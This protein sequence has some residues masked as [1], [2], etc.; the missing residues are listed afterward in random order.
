VR[1]DPR[2]APAVAA[3]AA[4]TKTAV[5]WLHLPQLFDPNDGV[6]AYGDDIYV[7]AL[8]GDLDLN[9]A[10]AELTE[11]V[12]ARYGFE[13][14][15]VVS[16]VNCNH[17]EGTIEVWHMWMDEPGAATLAQIANN[18]MAFCPT[19]SIE[20]SAVEREELYERYRNA[21][22]QEQGPDLLIIDNQF[23]ANL[24]IDG[25]V[26]DLTN[27]VEPEFLQRYVPGAQETMRYK[28]KLYGLPATVESMAMYYNTDLVT[29]PARDLTDLLNQAA[30]ERQVILP[31]DFYFAYWG[32]P[33]FGGR[34]FDAEGRVIL[35]EGGFA[36]WLSWLQR[37]QDQ[38]GVKWT[39]DR[40]Q[41]LELFIQNEAAY[42]AGE[43]WMLTPLQRELGAGKVGVVPLPAGPRGEAG[44]FLV[45]GGLLLNQASGPTESALALAFAKYITD[46]ES[47]T[48]L[49]EEANYVPANVNV[50]TT[51]H[52]AIGGF[53]TQARTAFVPPNDRVEQVLD[54]LYSDYNIY[55][56]VLVGGQNPAEAVNILTKLVNE[57]HN[58]AEPKD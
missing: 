58:A 41:A 35:N 54:M 23:V 38:P 26:S 43:K 49:M 24:V 53:L 9:Q 30:P 44:P 31:I 16:E 40:Q 10:A 37:A 36:E 3:A 2:V 52:P 20:L 7:K 1:I 27:L 29:D 14:G 5:P 47:Q 39:T 21:A 32:V 42:L 11:R 8:A 6:L 12:N 18:F 51:D 22:V 55:E 48:L 57:T 46:L 15:E 19:L 4:Q 33:A 50:D 28:G 45:V 34:L 17:L 56:E 25:L 13:F